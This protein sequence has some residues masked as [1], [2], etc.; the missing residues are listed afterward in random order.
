M[1]EFSVIFRSHISREDYLGRATTCGHWHGG[2]PNDI[3]CMK[4]LDV[5]PVI[6]AAKSML[7][8]Q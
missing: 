7:A 8:G 1:V 3:R 6:E 5:Q 2:C 4:E